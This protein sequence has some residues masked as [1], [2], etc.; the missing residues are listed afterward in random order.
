M[1]L[2]ILILKHAGTFFNADVLQRNKQKILLLRDNLTSFTQTKFVDNEQKETLR[3]GLISLIYRIKP[4]MKIIVR[5]D[6]HSSFKGLKS[7]NTLADYD[8][9]LDIGD[10]KNKNK[11]EVAEK[12]IQEL[13]EEIVKISD[14][15][16]QLSEIELAKAT[17]S[18]NSR[19]RFSERSAKELWMRRNQYTGDNLDVDDVELSDDQHSRRVNDIKSK[20]KLPVKDQEDFIKGE[21]VFIISDKDKTKKREPYLVTEVKSSEVQVVKLKGGQKVFVIMSKRKIFTRPMK[22]CPRR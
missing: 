16:K 14:E 5:V 7:D 10:E 9:K 6:P 20:Q 4:N 11:K 21:I 22:S 2:L 18:L 12:A 1:K 17:D 13:H 8:I 19:I 3:E 15:T